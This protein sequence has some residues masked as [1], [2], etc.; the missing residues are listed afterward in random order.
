MI[1]LSLMRYLKQRG[2]P[3]N[4]TV[5][6]Y[7]ASGMKTISFRSLMSSPRIIHISDLHFTHLSHTLDWG[8]WFDNLDAEGPKIDDQ[9]SKKKSNDI[10]SFLIDNLFEDS[11]PPIRNIVVI[12]GDLTDSGDDDDYGIAKEFI[13]RLRAKGFLVYANPGNH[14]YCIE[15]NII[16]ADI[17]SK[18]SQVANG[19]LLDKIKEEII[20]VLLKFNLP[21]A[22]GPSIRLL[23]ESHTD[24]ANNQ[25]RRQR[26]IQ[27]ISNDSSKYPHV[28]DFEGGRLILLDSMQGGL[29][30]PTDDHW[31]QGKLG[32]CQLA[33]LDTKL[34][35]YQTERKAGKKVIVA[36]HHSPFKTITELSGDSNKPLLEYDKSKG[37]HDREEFINKIANGKIDCLLFGHTTPDKQ[38]HRPSESEEMCFAEAEKYYGIPFINCEN[39]EPMSCSYSVTVLD[40]GSYQRTVFQTDKSKPRP[41]WGHP[42][43]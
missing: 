38:D 27:S 14:D 23:S 25:E 26:F 3:K 1:E 28:V 18:I 31:A 39:L 19:D 30:E 6:S 12:T 7:C 16:L 34:A 15:G 21:K 2:L 32:D 13:Q 5:R 10:A 42:M 35:E 40:L 29:N 8:K 36:L 11:S 4:C 20:K 33:E 17:L 9:N 22:I 41:S 24:I 43:N 37:L